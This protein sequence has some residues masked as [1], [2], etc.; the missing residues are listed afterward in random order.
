MPAITVVKHA[1]C[2]HA[3]KSAITGGE[4]RELSPVRDSGV[5]DL[6]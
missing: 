3:A 1:S 2:P 4:T 6:L 5:V